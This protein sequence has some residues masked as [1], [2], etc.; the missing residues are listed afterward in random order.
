MTQHLL[1]AALL[2]GTARPG[3]SVLAPSESATVPS[4]EDT[5]SDRLAR[6]PVPWVRAHRVY[7]CSRGVALWLC[8]SCLPVGVPRAREPSGLGETIFGEAGGEERRGE[9][10]GRKAP[11]LHELGSLSFSICGWFQRKRFFSLVCWFMD[12][13]IIWQLPTPSFQALP[14]AGLWGRIFLL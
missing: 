13:K 5:I 12:R 10:S 1:Q 4:T 9:G 14:S 3:I 7:P 11:V 2:R 8:L 6:R